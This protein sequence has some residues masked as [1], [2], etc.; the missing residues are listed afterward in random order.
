VIGAVGEWGGIGGHSVHREARIR[1]LK[2]VSGSAWIG[3]LARERVAHARTEPRAQ[4]R[5][6]Q[7]ELRLLARLTVRS[8][9]RTGRIRCARDR[10]ASFATILPRETGRAS[11][12]FSAQRQ[13]GAAFG[14]AVLATVPASLGAQSDQLD[15]FRAGFGVAATLCMAS[16]LVALRIRDADAATTGAGG[17]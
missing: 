2:R 6:P 1:R 3:V 9:L 12:L 4:C 5:E 7:T 13:M 11:A 16:A 8:R 10:A 17:S 15:A 14:V